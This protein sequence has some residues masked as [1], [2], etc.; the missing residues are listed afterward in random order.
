MRYPYPTHPTPILPHP[1]LS[2]REGGK[3]RERERDKNSHDGKG[4]ASSGAL[5]PDVQIM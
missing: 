2:D 1:T 3:A 5:K 4:D